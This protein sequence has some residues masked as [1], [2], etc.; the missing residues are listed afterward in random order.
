MS[1]AQGQIFKEN[2][3]LITFTQIL[4]HPSSTSYDTQLTS[5]LESE[6]LVNV[7]EDG[8]GRLVNIQRDGVAGE[9]RLGTEAVSEVDRELRAHGG[10]PGAEAAQLRGQVRHLAPPVGSVL[11]QEPDN[12]HRYH[13][14]GNSVY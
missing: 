1:P 11:P 8:S 3:E 5:I 4:H 12:S 7:V 9:D 14:Q 6:D 10:V 13:S 2:S